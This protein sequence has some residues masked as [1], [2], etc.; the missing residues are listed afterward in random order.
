M[1]NLVVKPIPPGI[2]VDLTGRT[3]GRLTVVGF[4]ERTPKSAVKWLCRCAC[5]EDLVA[6]HGCLMGGSSTRC[7]KCL[8]AENRERWRAEKLCRAKALAEKLGLTGETECIRIMGLS[9]ERRRQLR[10]TAAGLCRVCRGKRA[11]GLM[12]CQRCSD[13]KSRRAREARKQKKR[14][15]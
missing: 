5:G 13:N 9:R 11:A 8:L 14:Q 6:W 1:E 4:F 7:R 10:N 3:F 12:M 15:T 2:Q